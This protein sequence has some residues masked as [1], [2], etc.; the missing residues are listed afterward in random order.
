M[1]RLRRSS[2]AFVAVLIFSSLAAQAPAPGAFPVPVPLPCAG[3]N[4]VPEAV[5]SLAARV[6]AVT[7][8][9]EA[10]ETGLWRPLRDLAEAACLAGDRATLAA[11]YERCTR[12]C[13]DVGDRYLAHL[14]FAGALERFGDGAG[15]ERE[16]LAAIALR[17]GRPPEAIEAYN[18]YA[19]LLDR[20]G[21]PQ[22]ALT[23]L[24]RFTAEERRLYSFAATLRL[25]VMR[26]LGMDITGEPAP[27][28]AV[29]FAPGVGL[30]APVSPLALL[31]GQPD[32]TPIEPLA[33]EVQDEV[34]VGPPRMSPAGISPAVRGRLEFT[35]MGT[36]DPT[37]RP[38]ELK[39]A[40][41]EVFT[42]VAE[43]GGDG[44]RIAYGPATYDLIACPWRSSSTD[45]Q[46]DLYR[47][48][49]RRATERAVVDSAAAV[50]VLAPFSP[51]APSSAEP[52][53]TE[54]DAWRVFYS[55]IDA[56]ARAANRAPSEILAGRVRF[57][58]IEATAVMTAARDFLAAIAAVDEAA[59]AEIA[60]RF[61]VPLPFGVG[62][63]PLPRDAGVPPRALVPATTP[64]GRSVQEV[65]AA[66]GF[67]T[68]VAEQK[69]AALAAHRMRLSEVLGR[70]Q[71]AALA[72]ALPEVTR[73]SLAGPSGPAALLPERAPRTVRTAAADATIVAELAPELD[74]ARLGGVPS[75]R[76]PGATEYRFERDF[77][78]DGRLELV[79][80][81]RY[82][83][84]KTF[85]LI[86]AQDGNLWRRAALFSFSVPELHGRIDPLYAQRLA[87]GFCADCDAGGW[88][89]RDGARYV[90][91]A[92]P[93][94]GLRD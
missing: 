90:F 1:A 51:I 82:A 60:G 46:R 40:R 29:G 48:L 94:S 12:E 81:G 44:C 67:M 3:P 87:V 76:R 38:G 37:I 30:R 39:L 74:G 5:Q 49:G 88:L 13:R 28:P 2:P 6:D 19:L 42:V 71:L 85:A 16:Y 18:R 59:R 4:V 7:R 63:M 79:L 20:Q 24:D 69:A 52:T 8:A 80:L 21:R 41:G 62:V 73:A 22:D 35:R 45:R 47:V 14:D 78:R 55:S 36:R 68:R 64:D 9:L 31:P 33:I 43:L 32:L 25:W 11:A 27:Q 89:E 53:S 92:V 93:S 56:T 83:S 54:A 50:P 58:G 23:V 10:G 65:L 61:G 15:A 34:V 72:A 75:E 70:A 66:E 86:A 57:S 77:D 17:P 26:E 84:G 91:R